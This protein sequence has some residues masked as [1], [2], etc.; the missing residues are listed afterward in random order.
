VFKLADRLVPDVYRLTGRFPRSELFGL[1]S[2]M[3]R[4]AYSVP[5]NLVEG[6]ARSSQKDFARFVDI[7]VGSREEV[8]YQVHLARA[9]GYTTEAEARELEAGFEN[10]KRMLARLLKKVTADG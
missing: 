3:R 6:A 1:T 5:M 2:Q 9:L 4:A 10:V 7:A 8:R